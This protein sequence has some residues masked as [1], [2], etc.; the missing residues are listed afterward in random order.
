MLPI[1]LQ[2]SLA[3]SDYKHVIYLLP[4]Q[5]KVFGNEVEEILL[6]YDTHKSKGRFSVNWEE[7]NAKMWGFLEKFCSL[8]PKIRLIKIDYSKKKVKEVANFFFNKN[9]IPAK[10]WR[11]GP[12]YTYFFGIK[13]AKCPNVFHID[14]DLFFGGLSKTWLSEAIDLY[15]ADESILFINPLPGPPTNDGTLYNQRYFNYKDLPNHYGFNTMSTRLYLVNKNRLSSKP[16]KNILTLKPRELIRAII[17]KNPPFKLPEEFL[18]EHMQKHQFIRVDFK[19]KDNGL[20][21]LHPPYRTPNFYTQ[22]PSLIEKIE[23]NDIPEGQKGHYDIV[24]DLF[25]WS[26]A[27]EKLKF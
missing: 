27:R 18:S 1:T 3:P 8:N 24:D 5:I 25:D 22:L 6:T 17:R 26:E 14:S 20:W 19:G 9:K 2:I 7:N 11:G 4:H 16:L 23:K 12:F 15:N 21:S 13:E 10:D